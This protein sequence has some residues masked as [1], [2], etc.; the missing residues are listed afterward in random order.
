MFSRSTHMKEGRRQEKYFLVHEPFAFGTKRSEPWGPVTFPCTD[1][2]LP[3][4]SEFSIHTFTKIT[5]SLL[6]HPRMNGEVTMIT[7]CLRRWITHFWN[8]WPINRT[9]WSRKQFTLHSTTGGISF[10][11]C[12]CYG[13]WFAFSPERTIFSLPSRFIHLDWMKQISD[14]G[15]GSRQTKRRWIQALKLT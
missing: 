7:T 14:D 5:H 10:P 13:S 9:G 2:I 12:A 4:S 15:T 11:V 6:A 1:P 3:I 8:Q